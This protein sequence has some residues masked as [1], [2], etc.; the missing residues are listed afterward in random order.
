MSESEHKCHHCG[1]EGLKP[2]ADK[3]ADIRDVEFYIFDTDLQYEN[4]VKVLTCC[5]KCFQIKR[6]PG[7]Q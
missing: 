6:Y 4:S 7:I 2:S 1:K 5:F 3:S